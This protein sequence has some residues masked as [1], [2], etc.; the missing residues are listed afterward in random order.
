MHSGSISFQLYSMSITLYG[1]PQQ[2]TRYGGLGYIVLIGGCIR[3]CTQV[4]TSV[5]SE[6][7]L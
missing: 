4:C 3:F 7:V 6:I 1:E 5:R 2:L